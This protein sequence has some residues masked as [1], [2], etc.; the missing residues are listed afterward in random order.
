[1]TRILPAFAAAALVAAASPASAIWSQMD[2]PTDPLMT[3]AVV[4]DPGGE[5]E[6]TFGGP[7]GRHDNAAADRVSTLVAF[8]DAGDVVVHA[9]EGGRAVQPTAVALAPQPGGG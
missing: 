6:P 9:F 7:T 8:G 3:V 5:A 1:M 4:H 2:P